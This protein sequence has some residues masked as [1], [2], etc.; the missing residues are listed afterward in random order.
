MSKNEETIKELKPYEVFK[1]FAEIS[2]VP[3]GS[4]NTDK[5]VDYLVDF[6]IKN[7]LKYKKDDANNVI[8]I[9]ETKNKKKSCIALQAHTD[10]VCV[11]T[12]DCS[13]DMTKE[14]IEFVVDGNWLTADKTTLGADDGIGMAIILAILT[15]ENDY[16]RDVVGIFT[17]D[18]EI[19]LLGANAIDLSDIKV[20]KLINLDSEEFGVAVTGCAGGTQLEYEKKCQLL[21]GS[22]GI[23]LNIEVSGLIGGHSGMEIMKNRRN[24]N[25][26]LVEALYNIF[27]KIEFGIVSI[28]GGNFNNAIPNQSRAKI[29]IES[30]VS[31]NEITSIIK[32]IIEEVVLKY[33]KCEPDI[34]ITFNIESNQKN[35]KIISKKE[36]K[37]ILDA[38]YNL[39]DG[40]IA[41]FK[42]KPD[43]AETS[44]NLGVVKTEGDTIRI[45]NLV[46]SNVN[47]KREKLNEEVFAILNKNGFAKTMDESYP[48]WEYKKTELEE[49]LTKSFEKSFDK[50]LNV[51]IT[52]G[53]L[54]C[55]ILLEKMKGAEA[56]AI[57]P[58][59]LGA[60]TTEEKLDIDTVGK[61]Y[62]LLIKLLNGLIR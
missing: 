27:Q 53:G 60:H 62:S 26:I 52:H 58:T 43:I 5:I 16:D 8:I 59:I 12:D 38:L 1:Y 42:D 47:E 30:N 32:S 49:F 4:G 55:G 40:L 51:E 25:K 21:D 50:K 39:P 23:V 37:E 56:I 2:D 54:E 6:A 48:A 28:N 19:G 10:M 13:K 3:R 9:K 61:I 34:S 17:N 15:D 44:L 11:K 33:K 45:A 29:V 20:D 41:T 36:T 7:H 46:R 24:A 31:N 18:E 22:K 14:G 57:G 35:I